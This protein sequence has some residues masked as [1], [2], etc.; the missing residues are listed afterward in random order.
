MLW[1]YPPTKGT[2]MTTRPYHPIFYVLD[3]EQTEA[4]R[5]ALA[6]F[7]QGGDPNGAWTN[8]ACD[9]MCLPRP[10]MAAM[11]AMTIHRDLQDLPQDDADQ[12]ERARL[13]GLWVLSQYHPHKPYATDAEAVASGHDPMTCD[14]VAR[15]L[16]EVG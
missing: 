7:M 1:G 9:D 11:V 12:R 6:D 5:V 15:M 8:D 2:I 13:A 4:A 16:G 3:G 10:T 14:E